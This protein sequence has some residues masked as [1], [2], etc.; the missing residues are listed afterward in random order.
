MRSKENDGFSM[1][2]M[3]MGYERL[4]DGDEL[5]IGGRDW[6]IVVGWDNP[7]ETFYA[8][9][10]PREILASYRVSPT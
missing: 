7:L 6:E 3:P 9:D 8:Q 1:P 2:P 5:R 4:V 10:V